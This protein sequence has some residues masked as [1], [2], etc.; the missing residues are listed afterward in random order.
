MDLPMG[1]TG[2]LKIFT[3]ATETVPDIT[4]D[5]IYTGIIVGP[6][7]LRSNPKPLSL[8]PPPQLPLPLPS[9]PPHYHTR[10]EPL[11]HGDRSKGAARYRTHITI[12]DMYVDA[13]LG[14]VE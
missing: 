6:H 13:F 12:W 5:K 4:N 7:P 10:P 3:A 2:Y 1:W 11:L 8:S 14:M 9:T